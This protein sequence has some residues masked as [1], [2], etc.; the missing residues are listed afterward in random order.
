M[1]KAGVEALKQAS[2][3]LQFRSESDAPFEVVEWPGEQGKPDKARVLE[4]AGLPP[5]T[6]VKTKSL[7]AFFKE[8][9]QEQDWMDEG[10]KAEAQKFKQLVQTLKETLSDIKVFLAGGADMARTGF[11]A[12]HGGYGFLL[13][14]LLPLWLLVT[15]IG[16]LRRP[17]AA[18]D[19][20]AAP[21]QIA[22][23][24]R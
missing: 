12:P 8:A 24:V 18:R 13:F 23:P 11:F 6:P 19:T 2:K 22:T 17:P 16:L 5:T 21:G 1:K 7:D 14:W 9:T 3:G 20:A 15:G 4:L 10:E